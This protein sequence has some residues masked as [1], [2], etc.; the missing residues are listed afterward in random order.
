MVKLPLDKRLQ[1]ALDHHL[2]GHLPAADALYRAIL[3]VQPNH[4]DANYALVQRRPSPCKGF[5]D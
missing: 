2:A 5:G 4:P 3:Q 1:Q